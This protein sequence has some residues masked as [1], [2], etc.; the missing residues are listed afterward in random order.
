MAANGAWPDEEAGKRGGVSFDE[1][2]HKASEWASV[3]NDDRE[4]AGDP[5]GGVVD[6]SLKE[7]LK[8]RPR[9]TRLNL[10][11]KQADLS[12]SKASKKAANATLKKKD[13]SNHW[14]DGH[15]WEAWQYYMRRRPL[16][17]E[18]N[19]IPLGFKTEQDVRGNTTVM[20][21]GDQGK[22]ITTWTSLS[23]VRLRDFMPLGPGLV[24]TFRF[25]MFGGWFFL[26]VFVCNLPAMVLQSLD[27][28]DSK[29]LG[30]SLYADI[31]FMFIF[32]IFMVYLRYD[33]EQIKVQ[34]ERES[35]TTSCFAVMVENVPEDA[36]AD[37]MSAYFEQWGQ[38]YH[39][40]GASA[41][42]FDN[43]FDRTGVSMTF[44]NPE[45]I[46]VGFD[47]VESIERRKSTDPNQVNTPQKSCG[48]CTGK[49]M[50]EKEE[51]L[52]KK[53]DNLRS[54]HYKVSGPCFVVFEQSDSRDACLEAFGH[55]V[56]NK[57]TDADGHVL[58]V[59]GSAFGSVAKR[60]GLS[61]KEKDSKKPTTEDPE[62]QERLQ[63]DQEYQEMIIDE[64]TD[65]GR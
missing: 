5:P 55:G 1:V 33:T 23:Q 32:C 15:Y 65:T 37:E 20:V 41:N 3:D 57:D 6:E 45:M 14:E 19:G 43:D 47:L 17:D 62:E 7:Q 25:M 18:T 56:Q 59:F 64:K 8:P 60:M 52:I 50:I 9:K 40:A 34:V 35:V 39:S 2:D 21:A 13:N 48:C 28:T 30:S 27:P 54:K 31:V 51:D 22:P 26:A 36:T 42:L 46:R 10:P 11:D 61:E 29:W 16:Q 58:D 4:H 49:S 12:V 44:D 24:A 53:L 63:K 38:L